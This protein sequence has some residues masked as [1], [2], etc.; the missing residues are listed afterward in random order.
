MKRFRRRMFNGVAASSL[1]LCVLMIALTIRSLSRGDRLTCTSLKRLSFYSVAS[2]KGNFLIQRRGGFVRQTRISGPGPGKVEIGDFESESPFFP[3]T[4]SYEGFPHE[5][6]LWSPLMFYYYSKNWVQAPPPIS[7]ARAP[8]GYDLQISPGRDW[9]FST[10]DWMIIVLTAILPL[11]WWMLA[12]KRRRR[13]GGCKVCGY[14][15]RATPDRC[16]EC[17]ETIDKT[18]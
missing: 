9:L 17:G 12:M 2:W 7:K 15:L 4:W 3:V 1:L 18:A 5:R 10:P 13:V 8:A 14:D 11:R 16:P 6:W